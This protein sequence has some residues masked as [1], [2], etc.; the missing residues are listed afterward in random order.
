MGFTAPMPNV[1]YSIAGTPPFKDDLFTTSNSNEP[2]LDWL[3]YMSSQP[4]S[5]IPQVISTSCLFILLLKL[6]C[7]KKKTL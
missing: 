2:Y 1:F 3:M 5:A 4:D 7:F 6:A